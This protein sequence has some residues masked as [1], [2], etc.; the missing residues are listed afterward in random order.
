ME[1]IDFPLPI[2]HPQVSQVQLGVEG[3][4][5]II[6]DEIIAGGDPR[7]F[8]VSFAPDDWRARLNTEGLSGHGAFECYDLDGEVMVSEEFDV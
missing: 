5:V 2:T 4:N 3:A 7:L 1:F 8:F 6:G